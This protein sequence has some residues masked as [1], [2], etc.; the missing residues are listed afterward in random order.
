MEKLFQNLPE[1]LIIVDEVAVEVYSQ[2]ITV[3]METIV[4]VTMMKVVEIRHC[5]EGAERLTKQSKETK[6]LIMGVDCHVLRTRN[7]RMQ[8][9]LLPINDRIQKSLPP[10]S[11]PLHTTSQLSLL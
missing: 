2:K 11:E 3:Q 7:D 4:Q 8:K 10:I 5:E 1:E 9:S 6:N